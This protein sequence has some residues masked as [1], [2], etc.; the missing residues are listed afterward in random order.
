[1]RF[2]VARAFRIYP[3]YWVGLACGLVAIRLAASFWNADSTYDVGHILIQAL[4]GRDLFWLPS[5]DGISW[6]LEVEIKFYLMCAVL[7]PV[8]IRGRLFMLIWCAFAIG[9]LFLWS[10]QSLNSLDRSLPGSAH[11]ILDLQINGV[12]ITFMLIGVVFHFH[13]VRAVS[14]LACVCA[15]AVLFALFV[16]EW[17]AGPLKPQVYGVY[18]YAAAVVVFWILYMRRRR[19][20]RSRVLRFFGDLSYPL[21]ALHPLVGYVGLALALKVGFTSLEALGLVLPFLF[22]GAWIL[23]RV[24]EQPSI[25]M[26]HYLARAPDAR[27]PKEASRST[28]EAARPGLLILRDCAHS[29]WRARHFWTHLVSADLAVKTRIR[30]LRGLRGRRQEKR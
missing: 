9:I 16:T 3:V 19:P 11:L 13:L 24:V 29:V 10:D 12:M 17:H 28:G 14:T 23:H 21:Y 6:T 15:V 1:M 4:L 27:S 20:T 18:N 30:S 22:T 26:G 5:I 7:A 2:L 8:L 25:T